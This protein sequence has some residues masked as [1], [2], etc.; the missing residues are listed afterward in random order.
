MSSWRVSGGNVCLV[1]NW[2]RM[3][4]GVVQKT[5]G[6]TLPNC[7]WR[8]SKGIYVYVVVGHTPS[9]LHVGSPISQDDS[10]WFCLNMAS[11]T[12]EGPRS[13]DR[14]VA[15]ITLDMT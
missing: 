2:Y 5:Q 15:F 12:L 13:Q 3:G 7:F 1:L 10:L 14:N 11:R 4:F 9:I 6:S 8:P